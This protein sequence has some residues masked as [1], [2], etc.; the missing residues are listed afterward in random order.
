MVVIFIS[1]ILYF[2]WQHFLLFATET[3]SMSKMLFV[4]FVHLPLVFFQCQV[5]YYDSMMIYIAHSIPRKT[6]C[7]V[8]PVKCTVFFRES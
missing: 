6:Y 2:I 3:L 7:A 8:Y 1:P 4:A 5:L